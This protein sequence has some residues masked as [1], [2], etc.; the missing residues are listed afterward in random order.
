MLAFDTE[1]TGLLHPEPAEIHLQPQMIEIYI[2]KF[3]YEGDILDE[4][5]SFVKPTLPIPEFITEITHITNEMVADAP[6]FL[7]IYDDLCKFVLG[8]E[9][10]FAHN[11]PFDI[12]VVK[13]EL[14]RHGLE[15]NFPW[16]PKHTCTAQISTQIAGKRMRLFQLHEWATGQPKIVG[17]HRAKTD[18]MAMV[19]CIVKLKEEGYL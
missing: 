14:R 11:C 9:E 1:T 13:Y 5:K 15:Y 19:K 2:C 8:E 12:G 17:A 6:S 10:I 4:F 3:N 16:P 18:V 7:E